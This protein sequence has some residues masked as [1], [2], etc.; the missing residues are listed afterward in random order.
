[1]KVRFQ[2]DADLNQTILLAAVR[3]EPGID[4]RSAGEAGLRGVPDDQVL[5]RA[6]EANRI[7]LSHDGK[8]MPDEFGRFVEAEESPGLILIP[9]HLP[10]SRAVEELIL[11]WAATD[12]EEWINRVCWLP[13]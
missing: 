8:T 5:A 3:K 7:L 2:A 10:V 6:A 11:V 9:Q 4:F 1:M 12:P 13:L